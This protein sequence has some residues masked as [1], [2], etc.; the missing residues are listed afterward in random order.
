MW[1]T[2]NMHKIHHSRDQAE[3]NSNYGNIFAFH[4]RLFGTFV[5]SVRA[6]AVRY[7]LD[8]VDPSEVG[9]FGALLALPW[10]SRTE[11]TARLRDVEV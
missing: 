10:R 9:S 8:D 6:L 4:D 2:P 5:P 1:V 7:G 11:G 3:T